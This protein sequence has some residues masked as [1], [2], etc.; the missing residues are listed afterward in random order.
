MDNRGLRLFIVEGKELK[1]SDNGGSSSDPYVKLKFNGNS[2]KTETIKNTLSPVWNQS[3]DIGIINVNDPNA[4]IEVECLDWDRFG[5]HDS[6]GK[7]QLPIAILREAAT[8]G[9]TD[10][11]LNLD[12]KGYVRVGFQFNPPYPLQQHISP[13]GNPNII[14]NQIQQQNLISSNGQLP[15]PVYYEPIYLKT[16]PTVLEAEFILPNDLYQ[17][18]IYVTGE[19]VRA[20]LVLY[21]NQPIVVRSLF[22]SLKG[23]TSVCG[24]KQKELIQDL[25][26]LLHTSIGP[27]SPN[28]QNQKVALDIGKHIYPFE[29]FIPKHCNSSI[30]GVGNYKVLYRFQFNADIVNLPDIQ[31]EREITVVNIEDT[32]HRMTQSQIHEKCSK[33]PLTGGTIEMTITAPKNSY[34]PGEDIELQVHVN[35]SSKKKVKKIELELQRTISIQHEKGVPTQVLKV[36][37][38][39]FPKIQQNQQSTQI[40]VMET[41]QTLLNS[42]YQSGIIKIEYKVRAVLDI[43]DCIDLYTIFPV[44]IVLPD[45]KRVILPNPLDELSKIPRY[46]QDWTPRNL[47]SWLYFR[48]NCPEVVTSNPEFY[49]YCLSGNE[50]LSIPDTILLEKVL[51][52]AGTRTTEIHNAIKIEIDRVLSVR[53]ILKDNQLPHL[54][55]TFENE[56]VTFDLLSSLSSIDLSHLTSTIGDRI[57]L[58]NAFEKLKLNN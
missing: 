55:Q 11:W 52:G 53:T 57:R 22:V 49:Q 40:V 56:L 58:Q 30:D 3:F 2:F 17:K 36:S 39:F 21:V 13:D 35:N 33:S 54:I 41:P 18:T 23:K 25:R 28:S 32:V 10:K 4:I 47:L 15:P 20:S 31:L 38:N 43:L 44:N 12:K 8:F 48:M 37:K 50:L 9:Q 42:I 26:N 46:I 1:G 24:K 45:P 27:S 16:H 34:Y 7:V 5:K 14:Q 19:P 51:K 29:F 6:L